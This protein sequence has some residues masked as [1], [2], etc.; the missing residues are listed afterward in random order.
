M[1]DLRP[2][3]FLDRDGVLNRT[4]V[5]GGTPLPPPTLAEWVRQAKPAK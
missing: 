4:T 5:R 1:T 2:A 3:V